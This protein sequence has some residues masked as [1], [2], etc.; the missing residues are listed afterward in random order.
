LSRQTLAGFV[1]PRVEE[2]FQKVHEELI[3]SGYE[4]LIRAGIVLTGGSAQMPGMTELGEEIFHNTVKLG[5]PHY[6]GTLKDMVRNPRYSTV[7]GLLLEGHS[8]RKR[9]L[10]EGDTRSFRQ[11]LARMRS[12]FEKNF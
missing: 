5:A 4:R 7:M 10:K 6:D 12:W 9:G 2:I 1:Q 3:K 8:Q 11:V